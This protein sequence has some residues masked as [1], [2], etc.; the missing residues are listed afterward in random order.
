VTCAEKWPNPELFKS[1][2]VI[3]AFC[4]LKWDE[5]KIDQMRHYL[6]MGGGRIAVSF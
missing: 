2:D 6:E 3:V 1:A 4:Y 5:K